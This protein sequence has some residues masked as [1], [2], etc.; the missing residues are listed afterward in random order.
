MTQLA[1]RIKVSAFWLPDL[2]LSPPQKSPFR[3]ALFIGSN[4]Q[5]GYT[6]Q[7]IFGQEV[8]WEEGVKYDMELEVPTFNK[9]STIWKR[10]QIGRLGPVGR[11]QVYL[12]KRVSS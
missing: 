3:S 8:L 1:E 2:P 12:E 9:I 5:V 10:G 11:A 7:L 6:V 4:E